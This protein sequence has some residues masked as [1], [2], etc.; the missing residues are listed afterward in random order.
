MIKLCL[1]TQTPPLNPLP[2]APA[3]GKDVWTL[4]QDYVPQVGGVVPMMRALLAEGMGNWIAPR[5]RWVAL[6]GPRMP[7]EVLTSEGYVVE[8]V[9]IDAKE[10]MLYSRFKESV[11]SSFHGPGASRL[12]PREYRAFVD[13]SYAT[14]KPLL[15]HLGEFDLYYINDFQQIL[16]GALLGSAAPALLRW[17]IPMDFSGYPEPVRRFF[18][19]MMEGYDAIVVS[20]RQGL[21]DL[22]RVGFQGRAFQVYPYLDPNDYGTPAPGAV[23]RFR[24]KFSLGDAPIVLSLSRMDPVKRQDLLVRAF[25]QIHTRFPG[26][27]LVLAGGGSF[28]TRTLGGRRQPTKD[29]LWA[30]GLRKLVRELHLEGK[31]V[32]T[33]SLSTEEL[34]AAYRMSSLFVHPAPW[35]G[36]GLVAVEAWFHGAPVIVTRGAGVSE[37]VN[38]GVNGYVVRSGSVSSLASRI[39]QVLTHPAEAERMGAAGALTARQCSVRRAAPRLRA[40]FEHTIRLY[41]RYGLTPRGPRRMSHH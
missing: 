40:L 26:H 37:L 8:T 15:D 34:H 14:A 32:F 27:R 25:A 24:E 30:A 18:L 33:G 21:E 35:E 17:H 1:S 31:V 39:G 12:V 7:R 23:R 3:S 22:I 16:T 41:K 29:E 19:K 6:R 9:H 4:G 10:R 13:Y 36:F 2:G 5:P 38:D 28:S 11:W 20:T